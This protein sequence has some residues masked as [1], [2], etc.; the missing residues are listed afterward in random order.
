MPPSDFAQHR[1]RFNNYR[2]LGR[3]DKMMGA[4][5]WSLV[6][7]LCE[8]IGACWGLVVAPPDVLWACPTNS[9]CWLDCEDAQ[10]VHTRQPNLGWPCIGPCCTLSCMHGD[11][12]YSAKGQ[13]SCT[14]RACACVHKDRPEDLEQT[15]S[16][17]LR[18]MGN[19]NNG[20]SKVLV[21]VCSVVF[22]VLTRPFDTAS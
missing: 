14:L 16:S 13:W 6:G 5:G 9:C 12:S 20:F 3:S 4:V 18:C 22:D 1:R 21:V 8:P 10:S 17:T 15:S 11:C 19:T 7:A 2:W